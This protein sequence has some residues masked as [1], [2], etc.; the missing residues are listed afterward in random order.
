[1]NKITKGMSEAGHHPN[2]CCSKQDKQEGL[3][4]RMVHSLK[5]AANK[6]GQVL[7]GRQEI[8]SGSTR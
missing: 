4:R 2:T 5:G 3:L 8:R 1:M 7:M 6:V